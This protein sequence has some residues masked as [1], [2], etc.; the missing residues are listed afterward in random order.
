MS[1]MRELSDTELD[2][3]C[4]GGFSISDS[5]NWVKQTQVAY[6]SGAAVGGNSKWGNGGNA[7]NTQTITQS[8]S[9][10]F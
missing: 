9:A 2:A 7:T 10:S 1:E 4:G 8:Q 3:V 6:Q 5:Y